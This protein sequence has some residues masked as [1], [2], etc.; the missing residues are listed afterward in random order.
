M[1][2]RYLM[3]LSFF[4]L[5]CHPIAVNIC[6]IYLYECVCYIHVFMYLVCIIL[7]YV[8]NVNINY[9]ITSGNAS[10]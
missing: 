9:A 8:Q 1:L 6:I 4:T 10:V 5:S 2:P 7:Y 3:L